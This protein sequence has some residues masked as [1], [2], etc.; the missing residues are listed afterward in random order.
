MFF[1]NFFFRGWVYLNMIL[2]LFIVSVIF[3]FIGLNVFIYFSL[4]MFCFI[5]CIFCN[6]LLVIEN[7][8]IGIVWKKFEKFGKRK[9]GDFMV[10]LGFILLFKRLVKYCGIIMGYDFFII[11]SVMIGCWFLVVLLFLNVI[12]GWR[13]VGS[14]FLGVVCLMKDLNIVVECGKV[15][16]CIKRFVFYI[17]LLIVW[18]ME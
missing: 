14:F 11:D 16:F 7:F 18:I 6:M 13:F 8:F 4:V 17:L 1:V 5:L 15:I 9:V 10:F 3:N 12:V 2:L